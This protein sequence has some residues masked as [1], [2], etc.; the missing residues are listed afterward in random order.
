MEF[1]VVYGR[2]GTGKSSYIYNDIKKEIGKKKIYLV[3]P[4][5]S[6]L[7]AE[8]KLFKE[9]NVETL[10]NVEVLTLS[11]M[12]TRVL[13]E[14][15][16]KTRNLLTQV[17]K[18]MIIYDV[19]SKEKSKLKFL[20]KSD[21]NIDI[22]SNLITEFKKHNITTNFLSD[23][24]IKEEYTKLKLEDIKKIY[25]I[26][27]E[28]LKNSFIDENDELTLLYENL[29]K[30]DLFKDSIIYFDD[31][32]G[33]TSQE[34]K[35]F[36]GLIKQASKIMI[37]IPSD[38]LFITQKENDI[39][40]FNKKFAN[41]LIEIASKNNVKV[42]DIFLEKNNRVDGNDLKYLE[43]CFA[44]NKLKK[45]QDKVENIKLIT[46]E[47][48]YVE[49]E[50]IAKIIY[51]LVKEKNYRYKDF[52]IIAGSVE[53]YRDDI[54][55]IFSKYEIPVFVDEKKE[56]NQNILI[57]YI[58]GL[59][60]IFAK[61]WSFDSVFNYI[62][63]GLLD[64]DN[65]DIYEFENYC[66]KWGIKNKKWFE[67]FEYEPVNDKQTK[68]EELRLKI[69]VPLVEL[70]TKIYEKRNVFEL[71]KALYEF[72]IEN[73]INIILDSKIKKI[74]NIEIA[75][76]YNT[77]Y[78]ILVKL[79]DEIVLIFGDEKVSFEKYKEILQ[80]GLN[81]SEL[82]KIPAM[83]DG[84]VFGDISRSRGSDIKIEFLIG[85]NDGKIPSNNKVE[86]YF[87][88]EDRRIL[89]NLGLELAKDSK[90]NMYEEQFNIYRML[91]LPSE[92]LY[93]SY[94]SSD[95]AGTSIRPSILIKKITRIFNLK[96][97]D[98]TNF[99]IT[100]YK[101]TFE[102]SLNLYKKYLEG[103]EISNECK[104]VISYFYNKEQNQF[105]SAIS[106]LNYSNKA[107]KISK[108]NITR[109]YGKTLQTSISKL[110]Q[111]QGCPF[112]FHMKYG[113]KLQEKKEL[114]MR[115]IDT[116]SFMHEVIDEFFNELRNNNI[117]IKTIEDEEIEKIVVKII[118]ELFATS[119][120]YIFSSTAK[121]KI[122]SRRLKKVVLTSIK[123]IVYTL[124]NSKFEVLGN[125]IEFSKNSEYK[126]IVV[127]LENGRKVEIT[128]KIDRV[129][130][131]RLNDKEY[132]RII[133]YKS[134]I[135]TLDFNKVVTG[136]QIQLITYLD[137]ICEQSNFN[138]SGVLYMS[139]ID[140]IVRAAKNLSDETIGDEIKKNF[141]MQGV[142]LADVDVAK[143]MDTSLSP[144]SVTSNIVPIMIKKEGDII[145]SKSSVMKAEDFSNLQKKVK[146]IIKQIS[147]EILNGNVEIKPYYYQ[148][149]TPCEFCIYKN[150]CCFTPGLSG[151]EYRYIPKSKKQQILE[152]LREEN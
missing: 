31:F 61:N 18:N 115:S 29:E 106:G 122:L 81:S 4:E 124:K 12:A 15:G 105:E 51:K 92:A 82:G 151:N 1:F 5:Q 22:V 111:Y 91:T 123:Y 125:E 86:G 102:E 20:G 100:N 108:E 59:I 43:E 147:Q 13:D 138:P 96:E 79:L 118:N 27:E 95:K 90:D 34:Y 113:L 64:L 121:F 24:D 70:K 101:S 6:N 97:E 71:T 40:Y 80:V 33:F 131:G 139:L 149:A 28:K 88:D 112:S 116:G 127:E 37:T 47:N 60:D 107:E 120:Y 10:I 72:L 136:L 58:I 46:S 19:L 104:N 38:S 76:E 54:K 9:L 50:N 109:L 69:I 66:L 30:V 140:N 141:K 2:S 114:Q 94:C 14:V 148:R 62:K 57:K 129:D 83:Q 84:V 143:M 7:T 48:P 17:G 35:I 85:V 98:I 44:F 99:E 137:D 142:I 133:D 117:D 52:L 41:K 49:I 128:G 146:K 53:E 78:K 103:N 68:F 23:I 89:G 11:R 63:I 25:T 3:V 119:K 55:T 87:N 65:F 126:P 145:E 75:N 152:E 42:T 45:Y 130:V 144:D 77:S 36:E 93:I 21:K 135:K 73:K 150:I 67:K 56:L 32:L 110:E 26:Y 134:S 8:Q 132:V 16:E 74:N 39:F